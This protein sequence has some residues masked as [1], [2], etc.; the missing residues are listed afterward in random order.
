MIA[1][2]T[3]MPSLDGWWEEDAKCLGHIKDQDGD[4]PYDL[5]LPKHR[6]TN[7]NLKARMMARGAPSP[8]NAPP[9]RLASAPP[10]WSWPACGSRTHP[11]GTSRTPSG[12]PPGNSSTSP[13]AVTDRDRP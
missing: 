12:N 3:T 2:T 11:V 7:L 4:H 9:T 8:A 1:P 13:G 10:R 6:G 5:S